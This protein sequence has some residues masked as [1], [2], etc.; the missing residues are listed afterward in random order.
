MLQ[1]LQQLGRRF[2]AIFDL[3]KDAVEFAACFTN[4]NLPCHAGEE[5]RR[6]SPCRSCHEPGQ[7]CAL[8]DPSRNLVALEQIGA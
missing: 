8:L 6:S 2:A 3:V 7:R 5:A 4:G 1:A